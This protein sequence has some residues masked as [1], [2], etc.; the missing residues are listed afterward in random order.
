MTKFRTRLALGLAL[1]W[2]GSTPLGAS[3]RAQEVAP[4]TLLQSNALFA[5]GKREYAAGEITAACASFSESYRLL[6]R[7]GT[8]LNLGLC[9]E[10]AGQ[11]SAAWRTLRRA[12]A[13]A[14]A[15]GRTDRVPLTQEH[16]SA[17]ESKLSWIA[18]FL[19]HDVDPS[20][21]ALRLDGAPVPHEEWAAI[22]VEPGERVLTAEALG[23]ESWS[24]HVSVRAPQQRLSVAIGP[25]VPRRADGAA[26]PTAAPVPAPW[27][28]VSPAEPGQPQPYV[29][30][31]YGS[32]AP[33]PPP[34]KPPRDPALLAEQRAA[35]ESWIAELGVGPP[36]G[37]DDDE[38]LR[39][40]RAFGYETTSDERASVD[41]ALGFMFTRRLGLVAHYSW[42]EVARYQTPD[43]KDT[44]SWNTRSLLFGARFRQP[45]LSHW[46]VVFAEVD[47]GVSFTT[48]KLEYKIVP[49][50]GATMPLLDQQDEQQEH[51]LIVRGVLGLHVGFTTHLGAYLAAGY[52]HAPTLSNT[53]DERHSGGGGT[54]LTGVR[55]HGVKGWW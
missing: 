1:C 7:G 34:A 5:Q 3:V 42:L 50:A 39:T 6:P 38:Y 48:S 44:F 15:E 19:P 53:I 13:V 21:V 43:A 32:Y 27:P 9:Q 20:W 37:S 46:L 12:L 14:T 8:V 28:P 25:L 51:G 24:T 29:P 18:L 17:V 33:P 49:P 52:T 31:P 35:H 41:G 40:L 22:P 45:L 26:G 16:I 23:F 10:Q 36:I 47:A 2:L 30:L 54:L 11:L 55:L 4:E